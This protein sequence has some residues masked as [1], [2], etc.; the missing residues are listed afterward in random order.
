MRQTTRLCL[1][2]GAVGVIGGPAL[3]EG[4]AWS[5]A[6]EVRALVS[7]MMADAETR[8]SLLQSGGT[9][10]HDGQHFFLA[11]GDGNFRLDISGQIQFRYYLNFRDDE[12]DDDDIFEDDDNSNEDDFESGFQTRRTKIFF[13]GHVFDPNMFY[14]LNGTFYSNEG[15]GQTQDGD[16]ELEDAYAGYRWDNGF[17]ILWGQFK[18]P[19]MREELVSEAYQLAADWSLTNTVFTTGRSQGVQFG[20]SAEDFRAMLAFSDGAKAANSDIAAPR[21]LTSTGYLSGGESDWAGTGRVEIKL[22]GG[23]EAFQDFTSMPGSDFGAM[24]GIAGHIEGG[25]PPSSEFFPTGGEYRYGSWTADINLEGDGW[26]FYLAGVGGYSDFNDADLDG[27]ADD[28]V[29]N[30]TEAGDI[31]YSDYGVI[32]H[33][34]IFIPNTDWEPFIRYDVI[35][36]DEDE[37][38]L[39]EDS[40]TFQTLTFGVNYYMYGHASKFTADVLWFLDDV[41]SNALAGNRNTGIGYLTDDDENEITVR[42]QWQLLF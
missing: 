4:Q 13:E 27:I 41:S 25:D 37:R 3:A 11:S 18:L 15:E 42:L 22:A 1:L 39:D 8:S 10:G 38:E 40:E 6:D 32:A 35:F 19:F 31:N 34:G 12:N 28:D 33:A 24:L 23:W 17:S 26:N 7:E 2:A 20:W 29:D 9:A 30:V 14:K 5:N 21:G 16:F 36:A